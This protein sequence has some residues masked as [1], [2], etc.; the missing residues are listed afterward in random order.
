MSSRSML[1]LPAIVHGSSRWHL[2]LCDATAMTLAVA[3]CATD[4]R[5]DA[6]A[7][8]A[9]RHWLVDPALAVWGVW[10]TQSDRT[11]SE[12]AIADKPTTISTHC[13]VTCNQGSSVWLP[14]GEHALRSHLPPISMV[15]LLP[16]WRNPSPLPTMPC[17]KWRQRSEF[18]QPTVSGHAYWSMARVARSFA[19][20]I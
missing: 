11:D 14:N 4:T 13:R 1:S 15:D 6:Q 8:L 10:S 19:G 7:A 5:T 3:L 12:A 17:C 9:R 2:P 18:A 20:G 16:L